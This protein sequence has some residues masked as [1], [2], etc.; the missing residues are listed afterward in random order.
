MVLACDRSF[1]LATGNGKRS[2]LQRLKNSVPQGSVLAPLLFYIS[3]LPATVSI[4]YAYANDLAIIHADED[5]Q[6]VEGVQSKDIATIGEYLQTWKWKLST[7]KTV[8]AVFNLSNQ[9]LN[10]SWKSTTTTKPC[11]L[12]PSPHTSEECWTVESH[13]ADTSNHFSKSWHHVSH[14]WGSWMRCWSNNVAK[15]HLSPGPFSSSVAYCTPVSWCSAHT[16]LKDPAINNALHTVGWIPAS[17]TSGQ[18]S[19]PV[20]KFPTYTSGQYP[21]ERSPMDPWHLLHSVITCPSSG[22]ARHLK[23][24]HLFYTRCS[25]THQFI[26]QK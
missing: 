12:V 3:D 6:A 25:T 24:R 17:Y 4:K 13:T 19:Y 20:D 14:S 8:L 26:W 1:T 18:S 11:H 22:N 21:V 5:W 10:I 15:S 23:L 7:T 16:R 9:K 2:R